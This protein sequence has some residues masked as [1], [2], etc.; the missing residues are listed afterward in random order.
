MSDVSLLLTASQA[1]KSNNRLGRVAVAAVVA[2]FLGLLTTYALTLAGGVISPRQSDFIAY[3]SAGGLVLA[4]K[5]HALYDFSALAGLE[6]AVVYPYTLRYGVLPYVYPP[7]FAIA[8]API[9]L[10]TFEAAYTL[11]LALSLSVL[12]TFIVITA[13]Y[14]RLERGPAVLYA[15]AIVSF[16]PAFV[17]L[18]HGQ[19]SI[20]LLGLFT[21][22]L[23][24]LR[25]GREGAAGVALGL[26]LIK[27]P[28][29][30]PILLVLVLERRQR[31]LIAFGATALAL[32]VAPL[33]VLGSA[34][35][36]SYLQVLRLASGW[37][38]QFGYAPQLSISLSGLAGALLPR[39]ASSALTL[40]LD[41]AVLA[42]LAV[43]IRRRP[44]I[45]LSYSLA[46]LCGLL[47]SPHVLVHDLVIAT[48]P[49]AA[50]ISSRQGQAMP[51]VALLAACYAVMLVGFAAVSI[52][53]VQL[54]VLA[55]LLLGWLL[56][57]AVDIQH[58]HSLSE[59]RRKAAYGS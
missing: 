39:T 52:L 11:W 14:A 18:V 20:L 26:A 44:T 48:L 25:A 2:V 13:R 12:A 22:A 27:P 56:W 7:Y 36:I 3:Y 59:P 23:F 33:P 32:A 15:L 21:V 35:D 30:L 43:A 37:T 28:F 53:H 29:V 8:L 16:L 55:V 41:L 54:A 50:V 42:L 19:T 4:G 10:L 31:A 51:L 47:I 5:G 46:L 57:R 34:A 40:M 49:A 58:T 1:R 38:D 17:C 6:R 24:A 9:A 45:D